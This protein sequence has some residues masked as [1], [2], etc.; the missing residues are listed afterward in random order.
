MT[1]TIDDGVRASDAPLAS[2]PLTHVIGEDSGGAAPVR[3]PIADH[4]ADIAPAGGALVA[5][6]GLVSA[7]GLQVGDPDTG[8]YQ[9][10]GQ[11]HVTVDGAEAFRIATASGLSM[12]GANPVIDQNRHF[13]LRVY[14]IGTLPSAVTVGQMIWCSDLGGGA[15]QLNADGSSWRR[16]SRG[17][18]QTITSDLAFSLVTLTNAEEQ[19]HTGTLT[20]DRALTLSTT[21]AY[22]GARFRL[23]RSG[24]GAFNIT[25]AT[26]NLATNTWAEWIYGGSGWYLAAYGAL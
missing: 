18:Q 15:G 20:A 23:A 16:V 26:K 13:R 14:T 25:H 11:L 3:R 21:N 19:R 2:G 7:P 6:A 17:G 22:L 1:T 10:S 4:L 8:L 5:P 9:T 24:G 12:F